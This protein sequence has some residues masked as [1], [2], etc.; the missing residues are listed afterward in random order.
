MRQRLDLSGYWPA[1]LELNPQVPVHAP[2]VVEREFYVPLPWNKQVEHL[3][4]PGLGQ[5]LSGIV[6]PLQNQN[7]RDVMR[8]F[9]E[10]TIHYR[11]SIDLNG[12]TGVREGQRVFLVFD[13]SNYR[14]TV[15]L[16]DHEIGVHEGG[17]LAFEFEVTDALK[18]GDN[19]LEVTVDNLRRKDA[20]PQEQFNWQNYGGIY[21]PVYLE[22]RPK[23]FI[24]QWSATPSRDSQGWY[25][26]VGVELT[27]AGGGPVEVEITSGEET[28]HVVLAGAGHHRTG[29]VRFDTPRIWNQDSPSLSRIRLEC[30]GDTV[31]GCFGFRTVGWASGHIHINKTP[32][33]ILGAAWHEQHPAFGSSVPGWQVVRDIQLMKQV[34]LNAIRAAHYPHADAFY[35]AC[36]REGMLVVAELPCWQFNTHH[37]QS[38]AVREMCCEMARRMVRQLGHHPCIIG[39]I[40]QNE[41]K[42]FEPGAAEFFE[43]IH[44]AFKDAYPSRFT[45]T[46]ESPEPPEH[47]TVVKSVKGEPAGDLPPTGRFVDVVGVNCYAG[48]YAEKSDYLPKLLDHL[49]PK[50][51]G[52]ALMVTE[53]GAEGILGQ[54]S[55]EMHP[56]TED[57]QSHLVCSHIR[58]ILDRP[59]VAGFFLW[60]FIDY[61]AASITIRGINAKGLV[62]EHRRPKLAF[63]A[64]KA[65]LESHASR[66]APGQ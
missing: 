62:D 33:R 54:R 29:R 38:P 23:T 40:I 61:E 41:S 3:R 21:R 63:D 46:A 13:G 6:R 60:L 49:Q 57:Y 4:W 45:L 30:A 1:R 55:L 28:R 19:L 37:F 15:R 9:N 20:C 42:T 51:A 14:T 27:D 59:W 5:E 12:T 65:L 18:P 7:F 11:R 17:H 25:V 48:W 58:T 56:W 52:K 35:D 26:D 53:F 22:W 66:T 50:L 36:D 64:V 24:T 32:T 8:K 16:N 47:L 10:G 43:A 39:W 44:R 34:G 2:P 31:N